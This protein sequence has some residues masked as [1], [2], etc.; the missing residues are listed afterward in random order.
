MP[1]NNRFS[2]LLDAKRKKEK[3][4]IPLTKVA[5]ET[6]LPY[7]TVYAWAQ[8]QITRFDANVLDTLCRYFGVTVGDLL[9]QSE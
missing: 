7:K 2:V 1:I 3:R 4:K 8:N 6:G 9:E 5:E